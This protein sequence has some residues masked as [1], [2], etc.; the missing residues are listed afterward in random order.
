MA[1]TRL[2]R[3]LYLASVQVLAGRY[4]ADAQPTPTVD[5]GLHMEWTRGR[6]DYSAEITSDGQL[7][8]NIFAPNENDDRERV[9]EDPTR[10]DLVSFICRG[11]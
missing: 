7:I 1:P 5:G 4:L 11:V 6:Y 2:A 9:I 3:E 10:D 8:L